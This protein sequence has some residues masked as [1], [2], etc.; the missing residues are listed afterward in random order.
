LFLRDE[1]SY[2]KEG[3]HDLF[4]LLRVHG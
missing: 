2:T 1:S 4:T 3:D